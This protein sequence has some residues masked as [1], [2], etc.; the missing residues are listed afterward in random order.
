VALI[1][2]LAAAV[3]VSLWPWA[4]HPPGLAAPIALL[5]AVAAVC[6][7][8]LFPPPARWFPWKRKTSRTM[9]EKLWFREEDL[10]GAAGAAE[11]LQKLKT[12]FEALALDPGKDNS[13]ED[14]LVRALWNGLPTWVR[15]STLNGK[16]DSPPDETTPKIHVDLEATMQLRRK[17][18][19]EPPNKP[20]SPNGGH[21][22]QTQ[23]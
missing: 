17:E 6:L 15:E 22:G 3:A 21:N 13:D 1:L 16:G 7:L 4:R 20:G 8:V 18:S 9:A 11:F 2:I 12:R 23:S 10:G 5:G 14:R 19:E